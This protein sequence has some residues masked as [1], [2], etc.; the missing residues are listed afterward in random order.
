MLKI[1]TFFATSRYLLLLVL[2]Q[3]L[4]FLLPLLLVIICYLE[5][6]RS[7]TKFASSNHIFIAFSFFEAVWRGRILLKSAFS[8][9]KRNPKLRRHYVWFTAPKN[10]YTHTRNWSWTLTIVLRRYLWV[11][12]IRVHNRLF[13]F[14]NFHLNDFGSIIIFI[15]NSNSLSLF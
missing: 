5:L 14:L 13:E 6:R 1:L 3:K 12:E 2:V 11:L 9:V 4:V 10:A 8:V 15:L 7:S